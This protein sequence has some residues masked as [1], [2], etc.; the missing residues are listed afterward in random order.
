MV[1]HESRGGSDVIDSTRQHLEGRIKEQI[2]HCGKSSEM[3]ES[4][5]L[6]QLEGGF[7]VKL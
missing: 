5:E 2:V 7:E 1:L 4:S 6:T 3:L